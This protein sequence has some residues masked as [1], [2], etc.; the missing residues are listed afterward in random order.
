[1]WPDPIVID[2]PP[3]PPTPRDILH[4]SCQCP[5]S[6]YTVQL[7]LIVQWTFTI[8]IILVIGRNIYQTVIV[9]NLLIIATELLTLLVKS[10]INVELNVAIRRF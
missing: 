2:Q 8:E 7:Y 10:I 3:P 4:G 5:E 1:M 6:V 9:L